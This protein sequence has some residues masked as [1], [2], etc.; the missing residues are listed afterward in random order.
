MQ[1]NSMISRILKFVRNSNP[2]G[3]FFPTSIEDLGV[4]YCTTPT[5]IEAVLYNPLVCLILQGS[6]EVNSGRERVKFRAGESLIVSHDLPVLSRITGASISEPYVALFMQLD[7]SILRSLYL[8]MGEDDFSESSMSA[9]EIGKTDARLISAMERLFELSQS[10]TEL[11][12][13]L[14]LIKRE[15]HFRLLQARH[16]TMLRC[17]LHRGNH[18]ERISKVIG[19]LRE[20]LRASYSIPELAS[21]VNMSTSSF[22]DHFKAVTGLTPLQYQKEI[23]LLHAQQLLF[24]GK[25]SV[26]NIAFEVGYGS[27]TQFSRE[28]SRK[29][30]H[31]PKDDLLVNN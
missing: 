4:L 5:P 24:S 12:I 13:M 20:D 7:M 27:S 26:A 29:F 28:Y 25:Q 21:M 31:P 10:P 19:K 15:I 22:H 18:A 1:R 8:E 23:R 2:S 9:M 14:P 11:K 30:G 16:G 6:K 3:N 17:I